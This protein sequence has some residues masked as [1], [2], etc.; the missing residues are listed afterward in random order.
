[1]LAMWVSDVFKSLPEYAWV[2][3]AGVA[4]WVIVSV[5]SMSHKHRERLEM[6][7]QGI[8]PRRPRGG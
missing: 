4:G 1:M 8:D 2:A 3:I 5:V 6:I 7:R